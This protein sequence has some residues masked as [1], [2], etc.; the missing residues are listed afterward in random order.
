MESAP[1]HLHATLTRRGGW[2][3]L[4]LVINESEAGT[5]PELSLNT[6][7]F[8]DQQRTRFSSAYAVL[9]QAIEAGA[10]PGAAFGVVSHGQVVVSDTVGAF[11]YEEDAPLVAPDTVF[12][13]A[14]L[15]KVVA[16]T[17]AA[18]ILH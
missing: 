3:A 5:M 8:V 6:P 14:S 13:I 7:V 9:E 11:T 15:T 17:S 4:R 10:F 12:D 18:M 2:K 1:G 16:T